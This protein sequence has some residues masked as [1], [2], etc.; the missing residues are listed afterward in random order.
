MPASAKRFC[1]Q[2]AV[3][4][5]SYCEKNK[6]VQTPVTFVEKDG[7]IF[8]RAPLDTCRVDR[9]RRKPEVRL[10]PCDH[11]GQPRG[12]WVAG[13]AAVHDEC[14]L[15]WVSRALGEKYGWSRTGRLIKNWLARRCRKQQY[16]VISIQLMDPAS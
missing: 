14:E 8:T 9:M 1:G 6:P 4:I 11:R 7:Q 15:G 12:E 10:V 5:E 3:V 16:A 13:R 2:Q